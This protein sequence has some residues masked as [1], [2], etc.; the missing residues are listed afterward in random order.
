MTR[1]RAGRR[2]AGGDTP[3]EVAGTF[4]I[5]TG[6]AVITADAD[7]RG[8]L[9][10]VNGVQSSHIADDPLRLEFEYMRWI[11]AIVADT[12]AP[13]A[14]LR[15]LHLGAA[16]CALPRHLAALRPT[17][18]HVAVEIDAALAELVRTRL[19]IPRAPVVRLRVGDARAVTESLHEASRDLVVID[20]FSGARTPPHLTTVEFFDAVHRVLRPGGLMV[21]NLADTR[22][23]HYARRQTSTVAHCFGHLALIADPAML[24]GRRYGNIVVAAS[25]R[26]LSTSPALVRTLLVDAVPATIRDH[27]ATTTFIAGAKPYT[28]A[29]PPEHRQAPTISV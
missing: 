9:L 25:D 8:H 15:A 3:D 7:G 23:L 19:D 17:S 28:D 26:P 14:S 20:V 6:T 12:V 24:K 22:D 13:D 27:D 11:A 21:M 29:D 4:P 18:R 1:H 5:D 16:G 2:P 10:E